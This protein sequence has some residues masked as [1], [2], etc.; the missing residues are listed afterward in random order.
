MHVH[1]ENYATPREIDFKALGSVCCRI[2]LTLQGD[3]IILTKVEVDDPIEPGV[4][5]KYPSA[6]GG[7]SGVSCWPKVPPPTKPF[8]TEWAIK[9]ALPGV[10]PR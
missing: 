3:A 4:A 1:Q 10:R 9:V 6:G 5:A 8:A 7:P 2:G